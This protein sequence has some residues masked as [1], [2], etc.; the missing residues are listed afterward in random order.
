MLSFVIPKWS[1]NIHVAFLPKEKFEN[2]II[3]V[4]FVTILC[5]GLPGIYW[6]QRLIYGIKM[7]IIMKIVLHLKT[8]LR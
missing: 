3:E 6:F 7:W 8:G 2:N 4:L 5:H 1:R